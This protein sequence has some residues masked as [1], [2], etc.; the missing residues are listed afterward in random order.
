MKDILLFAANMVAETLLLHNEE[1][2]ARAVNR[3]E[4]HSFSDAQFSSSTS[5]HFSTGARYACPVSHCFI[6][7]YP[8]TPGVFNTF[9]TNACVRLGFFSVFMLFA[10]SRFV[11]VIS[12][13]RW[14]MSPMFAP[15]FFAAMFINECQKKIVK[16]GLVK[17]GIV[18]RTIDQKWGSRSPLFKSDPMCVAVYFKCGT[19]LKR[20]LL[21]EN[22]SAGGFYRR[23][24]LSHVGL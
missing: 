15:A 23:P 24:V 11:C 4:C 8:L 22:S 2:V 10:F 3:I 5:F 17:A 1:M 16:G 13:R 7:R 20:Y 14:R 18:A 6:R 21:Y 9:S 19:D 12:N